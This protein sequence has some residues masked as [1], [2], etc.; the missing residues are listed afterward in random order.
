MKINRKLLTILTLAVLLMVTSISAFASEQ[1]A[2]FIEYHP[3]G[4]GTDYATPEDSTEFNTP[5]DK[6]TPFEEQNAGIIRPFTGIQS[7]ATFNEYAY[8][9]GSSNWPVY[10]TAIGSTT[11]GSVNPRKI[12][13]V[14]TS[15]SLSGRY[16]IK[17]LNNGTI[18]YGYVS[19]SALRVPTSGWS[20][21]VTTGTRSNDYGTN[22][23]KGIDVASSQGTS[24][25]AVANVSHTSKHMLGTVNQQTRLVSFG[26]YISCVTNER[27]VIY[28]HLSS[29]TQGSVSSYPSYANE[30][31][32][33]S[34]STTAGSW[35]PSKGAKIGG[36]GSTGWSTNNHLH[37][38]VRSSS[39]YSLKYDPY[40]YVVFPDIN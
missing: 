25:Y 33:S 12:V 37:F 23:H 39:N 2:S 36:M 27:E 26:N 19:S 15:D 22:G 4:Y 5:V 38:E 28:A 6:M 9:T 3:P 21:P 32:G 7:R 16:Y 18:D 35:T 24:I 14:Y 17:F 40:Q 10:T 13:Y 8:V 29:F 1:Q 20:R 30:Y 34:W 31:S 11:K